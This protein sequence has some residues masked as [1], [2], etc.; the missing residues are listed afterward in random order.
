MIFVF[1][2]M[3]IDEPDCYYE[4]HSLFHPALKGTYIYTCM[5]L[6][7]A[8]QSVSTISSALSFLGGALIRVR[9][10]KN[11]NHD[12]SLAKQCFV[13]CHSWRHSWR[14]RRPQRRPAAGRAVEPAVA[15]VLTGAPA[16]ALA[17]ARR[18]RWRYQRQ[19]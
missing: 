8:I 17:L 7:L 4:I 16:S 9:G 6:H 12:S 19:R 15:A 2:L 13:S 11:T 10:W 18:L 3:L 5:Y 14:Q 1:V